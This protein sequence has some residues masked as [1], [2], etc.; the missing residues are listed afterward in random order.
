MK[1]GKCLY[2]LE[3]TM[4]LVSEEMK[5]TSEFSEKNINFQIGVKV[6]C[7]ANIFNTQSR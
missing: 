4:Q 2:S 5:A 7:I 1:L 3:Y 6:E